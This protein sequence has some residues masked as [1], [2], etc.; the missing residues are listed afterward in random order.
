[1]RTLFLILTIALSI[2]ASPAFAK[3]YGRRYQ[4]NYGHF[5]R[6]FNRQYHYREVDSR[7]RYHTCMESTFRSNDIV[8]IEEIVIHDRTY[9]EQRMVRI[10]DNDRYETTIVTYYVYNDGAGSYVR[11]RRYNHHHHYYHNHYYYYTPYVMPGLVLT[12]AMMD[13]FDDQSAALL[14]TGGIVFDLGLNIATGC[15]SDDCMKA[16]GVVA[17]LGVASS[18]SASISNEARKHRKTELETQINL[19]KRAGADDVL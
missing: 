2:L 9:G 16:A 12:A 14:L 4:A 6:G 15:E 13:S 8:Y 17:L 11:G 7:C 18:V 10:Y 1:M 19:A 5:D 3:E